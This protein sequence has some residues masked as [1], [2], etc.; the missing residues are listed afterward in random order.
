MPRVQKNIWNFFRGVTIG[1]NWNWKLWFFQKNG[2]S[3]F[4]NRK[5]VHCF[6]QNHGL[7]ATGE[8]PFSQKKIYGIDVAD[9][10]QKFTSRKKIENLIMNFL[11]FHA[12][13]KKLMLIFLAY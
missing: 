13:E 2:F 5:K 3:G 10:C 1:Q 6:E 4:K 9:R 11:S 8:N 12:L 7:D